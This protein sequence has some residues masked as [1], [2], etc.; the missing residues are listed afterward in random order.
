[1]PRFARLRHDT[2][3]AKIEV[4]SSFFS[5]RSETR[6]PTCY[7]HP[8]SC[9]RHCVVLTTKLMMVWYPHSSLCHTRSLSWGPD[10][11]RTPYKAVYSFFKPGC[12]CGMY[13]VLG[14]CSVSPPSTPI[15][16]ETSVVFKR[17]SIIAVK[18]FQFFARVL[19]G[20]R[21]R[22]NGT[23]YGKKHGRLTEIVPWIVPWF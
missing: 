19:R 15:V 2:K 18:G 5:T 20:T 10:S 16:A 11:C 23:V 17:P 4:M 12:T 8:T 22:A 9:C 21:S 7:S 13:P 1:M 14:Q 6:R 3:K